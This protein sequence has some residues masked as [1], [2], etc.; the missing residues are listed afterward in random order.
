MSILFGE[1]NKNISAEIS[2][3]RESQYRNEFKQT[4]EKKN[5]LLIRVTVT[6]R[7]TTNAN[8]K[9]TTTNL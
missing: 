3:Q 8:K 4:R 6:M 2:T 1:I 9:K 5:Q 7:K